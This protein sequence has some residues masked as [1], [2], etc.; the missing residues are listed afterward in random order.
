[1]RICFLTS[2]RRC[3]Q[4]R[5][6]NAAYEIGNANKQLATGGSTRPGRTGSSDRPRLIRQT[7]PMSGGVTGNSGPLQIIYPSRA[8]APKLRAPEPPPPFNSL[9]QHFTWRPTRPADQPVH[10][11]SARLPG[12]PVRRWTRRGSCLTVKRDRWIQWLRHENQR[13]YRLTR[14][15]SVTSC[16]MVHR[17]CAQLYVMHQQ[18]S[19]QMR[20]L[21]HRLLLDWLRCL[22]RLVPVCS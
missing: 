11:A 12:G 10:L 6:K 22:Q 8:L 17:M 9:L 18:R 20:H 16:C 5:Q 13:C 1:M 4:F 14:K 2:Y 7:G 3:S 19:R 21:Q 15:Y